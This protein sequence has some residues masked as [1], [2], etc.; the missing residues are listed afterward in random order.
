MAAILNQT[1]EEEY[2]ALV[3]AFPLAS[4]R[5]DT[6]LDEA[7][8]V[9]DGLMEQPQRSAAQEVYLG[10]LIDL[11][12]TYETAHVVIPPTSGVD[13]LR[14]LMETNGLIQADLV[15]LVG[16]PSVV[17]E[18]LAGKRRLAL[19]HIRRLSAYF[20]LP[21]DVFLVSSAAEAN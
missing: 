16:T 6:H 4:I 15:P 10:A 9:L 21:A 2:L 17:S 14:F 5:D 18:V 20:G 3:R 12:E 1:S 13:A 7:L 19:T 11:V 8:A